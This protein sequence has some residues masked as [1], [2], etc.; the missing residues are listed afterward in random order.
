MD[1]HCQTCALTKWVCLC[2]NIS[3]STHHH[4]PDNIPKKAGVQGVGFS[5]L[6]GVF[7]PAVAYPEKVVV[8]VHHHYA[9]HTM[10][11]P[12]H[13]HCHCHR[14]SIAI[15]SPLPQWLASELR[16]APMKFQALKHSLKSPN[17]IW[18]L[19]FFHFSGF[20]FC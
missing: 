11:I 5:K 15:I 3:L 16:Q 1:K 9:M 2:F 6:T 7:L 13:C 10:H 19:L 18:A 4:D 20:N 14:R 17:T 8:D 12:C